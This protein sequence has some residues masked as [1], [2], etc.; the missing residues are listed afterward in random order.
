M[1]AK[2]ASAAEVTR[3]HEQPQRAV[4]DLIQINGRSAEADIL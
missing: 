2:G 3:K 1:A 4:T